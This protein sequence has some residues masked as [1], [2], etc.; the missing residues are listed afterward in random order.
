MP[1]PPETTSLIPEDIRSA[2]TWEKFNEPGDV[3]K[4]YY[5]LEKRNGNSISFPSKD[6]TPEDSAKWWNDTKPK[7]AERGFL[8]SAPAAADKYEWK[9]EGVD[10]EQIGG[11]KVLQKFAPIAHELGLS[12]R[13][14][15][16]LV[17]KFGK[18]IL[19][20]LAPAP[21]FADA[22]EVLSKAFGSKTTE[23]LDN[24]KRAM[25]ELQR[26][27]PELAEIIKDDRPK[28]AD[29]KYLHLFDHPAMIKF[30]NQAFEV[31]PD[32]GGNVG[33]KVGGMSA[34]DIQG[35]L[36]T[37]M[38]DKEHANYKAYQGGSDPKA[39]QRVK[40][41]FELLAKTGAKAK[42]TLPDG[43]TQI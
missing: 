41:L 11:D 26:V 21:E 13:Q 17:E 16:A 23:T 20:S 28:T 40:E 9:F 24:Y 29:G 15:N 34:D 2:P 10:A 38:R 4:S 39:T 32:F 37:Y 8:E 30:I 33:G 25:A 42:N 3:F 18:D 31:H 5:E 1:L 36:N 22:K 14:A 12:N 6:A 27:N 35:E 19:P 7:L 43:V